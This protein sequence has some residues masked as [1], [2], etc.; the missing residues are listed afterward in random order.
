MQL[1]NHDVSTLSQI[2]NFGASVRYTVLWDYD[3][4]QQKH[5][6]CRSCE[7]IC[8]TNLSVHVLLLLK[9]KLASSLGNGKADKMDLKREPKRDSGR[10]QMI[11]MFAKRWP[12]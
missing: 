4:K 5:V 1:S 8:L 12:I 6:A 7:F 11:W 9:R 3:Q 10:T 2:G